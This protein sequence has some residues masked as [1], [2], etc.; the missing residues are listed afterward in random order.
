VRTVGGVKGEESALFVCRIPNGRSERNGIQL[1]L[2]RAGIRR[3]VLKFGSTYSCCAPP[4]KELDTARK[5]TPPHMIENVAPIA[6]GQTAWC[7][8]RVA[9]PAIGLI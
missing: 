7:R 9:S 3:D 2:D 4:S 5:L 8:G 1:E 6:Q